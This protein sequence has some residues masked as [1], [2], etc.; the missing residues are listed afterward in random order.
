MGELPPSTSQYGPILDENSIRFT[1]PSRF[2]LGVTICGYLF[3]DS[4]NEKSLFWPSRSSSH[5]SQRLS[6]KRYSDFVW[7]ATIHGDS[8]ALLRIPAGN[9]C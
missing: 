3:S 5:G 1:I 2:E 7:L 6:A 9:C 4:L 8:A